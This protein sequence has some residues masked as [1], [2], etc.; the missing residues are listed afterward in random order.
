[1]LYFV[2]LDRSEDLNSAYTLSK[3]W[4]EVKNEERISMAKYYYGKISLSCLAFVA[5]IF[6]SKNVIL[7]TK[8]RC[9]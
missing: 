8:L 5:Q 2:Q 3:N 1:M 9:C 7:L 4:I 6:A